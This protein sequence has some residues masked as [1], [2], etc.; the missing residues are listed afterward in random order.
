MNIKRRAFGLLAIA[1]LSVGGANAHAQCTSCNQGN[2]V[3]AWPS[4]QNCG[5][6]S[7][8]LFHNG[9]HGNFQARR[10]ETLEQASKISARNE[11]WMK[12][13]NCTDRNAYFNVWTPVLHNGL[14]TQCTLTDVHFDDDGKVNSMGEKK[15]AAIMSNFTGDDRRVYIGSNRD[16]SVTEQRVADVRSIVG[17]W[18]GDDL[19]SR[20]EA[21]NLVPNP[22]DGRR[23]EAINASYSSMMPPPIINAAGGGTS[24]SSGSGSGSGGSGSGQSGSGSSGQ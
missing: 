6:T 16:A 9:H 10:A 12:P 4:S 7:R 20:V 1:A 3:G 13:F 23:V 22:V 18:Y 14:I 24:S 5:S 17:K 15:I 21:T 11:A 19:A 8:G 2:V